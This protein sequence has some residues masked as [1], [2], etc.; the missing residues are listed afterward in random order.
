MF[1][2]KEEWDD[3]NNI[4]NDGCDQFWVIEVGWICQ[5]NPSQWYKWGDG[6]IHP[7]E[8]CDDNNIVNSDGCSSTWKIESGYTCTKTNPSVCTLQSIWGNG[9]VEIGEECDDKN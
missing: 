9:I 5:N 3:G 1:K 2:N 7:I 8:E 4:N 6:I